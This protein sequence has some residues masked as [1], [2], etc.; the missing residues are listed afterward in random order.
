MDDHCET[1]ECPN[2][3]V[4]F[5]KKK[6]L[7]NNCAIEQNLAIKCDMC[8]KAINEN[9]PVCNFGSNFYHKL[10][11]FQELKISLNLT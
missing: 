3:A 4:D 10:P 8:K 6:L 2:L 5:F 9:T 11:C 7:C 1:D